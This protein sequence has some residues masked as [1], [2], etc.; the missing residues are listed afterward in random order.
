M[1]KIALSIITTAILASLSLSA[2]AEYFITIPIEKSAGGFL[3]S[4]SISFVKNSSQNPS[5]PELPVELTE[6]EKDALCASYG[7]QILNQASSLGVSISINISRDN[8]GYHPGKKCNAYITWAGAFESESQLASLGNYIKTLPVDDTGIY[9]KNYVSPDGR[10]L[11]KDG[12]LDTSFFEDF[13]NPSIFASTFTQTSANSNYYNGANSLK[14]YD[15]PVFILNTTAL[16]AGV[17]YRLESG[18]A[19][20][21]VK[22]KSCNMGSTSMTGCGVIDANISTG[23][24]RRVEPA[25]G[26]TCNFSS[27]PISI[28]IKSL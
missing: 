23:T 13:K 21:V 1:K 12:V 25:T 19:S 14:I 7:P 17:N 4:G 5:L 8:F 10:W 15:A 20:C 6:D 22:V 24:K 27:G 26:E 2:S 28:K 3:P 16:I 11:I 9:L 18:S